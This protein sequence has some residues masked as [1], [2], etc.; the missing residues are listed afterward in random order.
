MNQFRKWFEKVIRPI[1][2]IV[3][4]AV[5]FIW[6]SLVLKRID[7][8]TVNLALLA[9][10]IILGVII[11]WNRLVQYKRVKS[12]LIHRYGRWY[13]FLIQF[14]FGG[15]FNSYLI[16]YFQSASLTKTGLFLLLIILL[17]IV[18]QFFEE[19]LMNIYVLAGMF[20]MACFFFLTFFLPVILKQMNAQIF[21]TGG[22]ISLLLTLLI[23]TYLAIRKTLSSI[24]V[25]FKSMGIV[26][27]LLTAGFVLYFENISPPVP[28]SM[29]SGGVYHRII[30]KGNV[31]HIW[32]EKDKSVEDWVRTYS[33]IH[34]QPGDTV[35]CFV[36]IFAPGQLEKTIY[37]KWEYY[38]S[39][40]QQWLEKNQ[41]GYTVTGGRGKGYRGYTFKSNLWYGYWRVEITTKEGQIL[42]RIPFKIVRKDIPVRYYEIS[43]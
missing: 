31:Y 32:T 34:F 7:N 10:I 14:I 23:L 37:Q 4:F 16:F 38:D 35:Y 11:I 36:S 28:L 27:L 2:P 26:I 41:I 8:L 42:G 18:S 39:N 6:Q 33:I 29:K 30:R 43:K 15:L 12:S 25:Y 21:I 9:E 22:I 24:K 1:L 19:K 13:P 40:K 5:G 3:S 17:L 20:F